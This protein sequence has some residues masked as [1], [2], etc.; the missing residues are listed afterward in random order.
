MYFNV[1]LDFYSIGS[2]DLSENPIE[3]NLTGWVTAH[4]MF[5]RLGES[6]IFIGP[7]YGYSSIAS[8][9]NITNPDKPIL[10]SISKAID[11]TTTF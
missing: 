6:N 11:K 2:V 3:V 8:S 5:F 9:V 7:Q 4:H 1:N 10:D